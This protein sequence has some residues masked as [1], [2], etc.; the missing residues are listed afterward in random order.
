[1]KMK[2][3]RL[4][5][6]LLERQGIEIIAGIPGSSN[7]PIYHV[8]ADSSIR[9]ILSRHEQGAGFIAHGIARSTGRPA[10]C[11]TTSGPG[12]TNVLTALADAKMDSVPIIVITGQVSSQ[13]IGSDAFQ[14][15]DIC[16]MSA[17]VTKKN[18]QVRNVH[19]LL[20]IIPDAFSIAQSGRPGPVLIDIPK[21]IQ[22]EVVEFRSFPVPGIKCDDLEMSKSNCDGLAAAINKAKR[23][24]ICIGG[25]ISAAGAHELLRELCEKNS[26]P[27]ATT[28]MGLGSLPACHPLNIGLL[29]MHGAWHTNHII[30]EADLFIALGLRFSDRVT[31]KINEFCPNALIAHVDIDGNEIGK[32]VNT[33][34]GIRGDVKFILKDLIPKLKFQERREW[35]DIIQGIKESFSLKPEAIAESIPLYILQSLARMIPEDAIVTTDV[36]QHQMWVAQHYPFIRPRTFLTSGGL[37]T[38]GFGIPAAIGA[39]LAHGN[40]KVICITGDGSFYMNNQELATLAE[41]GLDVTIILFNNRSL[42]LVRQQQELFFGGNTVASEFEF[43]PSF[44]D[45]AKGFGISGYTLDD[46]SGIDDAL[47]SF[48]N[49]KGPCLIEVPIN[50]NE[51]VFPIV[52]P[53]AANKEMIGLEDVLPLKKSVKV[54]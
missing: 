2:G 48:L 44:A 49:Q 14:E 50:E 30:E 34:Y 53:G 40:R 39:A 52:P 47:E 11:L 22:N 3:S 24:V 18:Y 10:V 4:I 25:G 23:P 17:P 12:A 9:H 36:G 41:Q 7:L 45:I 13:L 19:D 33:H 51:K 28:L 29:G 42:G 37:G 21:D 38:M 46:F 16:S 20:D 5:V 26:I 31:G 6:T 43:N 32:V 27:V 15:I 8:I 35:M 54:Q 1:M